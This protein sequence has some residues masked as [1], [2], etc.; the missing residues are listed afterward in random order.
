MFKGTT[1]AKVNKTGKIIIPEMYRKI[2]N[3]NIV[4]TSLENKILD[5]IPFE[6]FKQELETV[7][8]DFVKMQMIEPVFITLDEDFSFCLTK[9]QFDY[10]G[11]KKDCAILYCLNF[12]NIV[13]KEY[14]EEV[15]YHETLSDEDISNLE[16][17][18]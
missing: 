14:Y 16:K 7:G 2:F 10:L 15:I 9:E 13:S 12:L 6:R 5:I 1:F 4:I 18:L 11:L 17:Y 3:K 8:S